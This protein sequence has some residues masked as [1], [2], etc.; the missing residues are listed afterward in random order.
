CT[1]PARPKNDH[2]ASGH[3]RKSRSYAG[4]DPSRDRV[5]IDDGDRADHP[6]RPVRRAI[7]TVNQAG[8]GDA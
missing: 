1:S 6:V 2:G 4:R 8:G 7:R 5:D 3:D